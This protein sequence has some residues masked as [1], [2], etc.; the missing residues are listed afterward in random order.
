M[1]AQKP[2]ATP[3]GCAEDVHEPAAAAAMRV[4]AETSG[5]RAVLECGI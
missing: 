5:P 1:K 2:V 3:M 4:V